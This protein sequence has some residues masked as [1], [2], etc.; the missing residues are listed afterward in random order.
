MKPFLSICGRTFPSYGIV[1]MIGFI[2]SVGVVIVLSRKYRISF[3]DSFYIFI[4]G[5]LGLFLG[6]KLLYLITVLPG[7]I[8]EFKYI[9]TYKDLFVLKYFSSG[10]VFY[11]GMFGCILA[12]FWAFRLF[13]KNEKKYYPILLPAYICFAGFGRIGCFL[14]GCCY[15]K[16]TNSFLGV[17]FKE[18]LVA[19]SGIR[20]IP[21]QLIE[22]LFDFGLVIVFILLSKYKTIRENML[23]IYLVI[24]AVF[25]FF[26]EYYRGDEQRGIILFFS[27]SQ[28]ISI[29]I[30]LLIIFIYIFGNGKSEIEENID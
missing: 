29:I 20:L 30:I 13:M 3:S 2:F 17:V 7:F 15:G 11:G 22:A 21:T 26:L 8:R 23:R 18:S 1:G 16:E 28:W 27:T 12:S 24:Y 25:R 19:P 6:A 4:L 10:M 5:I 9:F 14:T